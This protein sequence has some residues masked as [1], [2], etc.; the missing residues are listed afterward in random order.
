MPTFLPFFI[1][2]VAALFFSEVFY[3]LHLPWVVA[4]VVAGI[5]IGPHALD[6]YTPDAT[7]NVLGEIGLIFLMFMAGLEIRLSTLKDIKKDVTRAVF[8][9]GALPFLVGF[10]IGFVFDLGLLASLLI[11]TIFGHSSV[12][13]AVPSLEAAGLMKTRLGQSIIATVVVEDIFSLVALSLLFKTTN[14]LTALPLPLFY[15][16]LIST[17]ILMRWLLPKIRWFFF[18]LGAQKK[19]IFEWELQEI[20]VILL[21]TVIIFQLIGLHTLIA[22]FFAGLVLSESVKSDAL[23]GKL[24]AISYGFFI[25]VFFVLIGASTNIGVFAETD[26][27]LVI[28]VI[29]TASILAKFISGWFAARANGFGSIEG[30]LTGGA[31]MA[32]LSTT[33]AV[34][35]AAHTFGIFSEELVTAMV[36]LSL[37]S[38]FLGPIVVRM[39][40]TQM[41]K[42]N[43]VIINPDQQAPEAA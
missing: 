20:F 15:L 2:L 18:S 43:P 6:I 22:G 29:V 27:A 28:V 42:V 39:A 7:M 38:T 1:I 4:L 24:R 9:N 32:Q 23:K 12:A 40:K 11:G 21:G 8:L 31:T 35:A 14:P 16:F 34:A 5:I 19:G 25:P 17:L 37:V 33:L 26:K 36:I 10:G 3:R 30:V 13:V 41:D